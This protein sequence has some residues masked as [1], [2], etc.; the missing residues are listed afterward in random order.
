M[1]LRR[2]IL[3]SVLSALAVTAFARDVGPRPD[4]QTRAQVLRL[5]EIAWRTWFAN[6]QEGFKRVVPHEL[7]AFNWDGGP[8]EDREETL[9]GMSEFAK[10][11][12]TLASL[13]FPDN[14]LQKYGE[15]IILYTT[16]RV[17]LAH[18]DG[19]TQTIT[20]RGTEV[21]V[22]RRGRWIHTGWHLD[23]AA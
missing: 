4:A 10:S 18:G 14:V 19:S 7:L 1:T 9:K 11:G 8:W 16:F 6:D 5:R 2:T 13:E 21:F 3:A 22:K 23:K 12:L 20:G 15:T 17:V